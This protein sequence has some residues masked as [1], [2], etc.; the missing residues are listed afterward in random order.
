MAPSSCKSQM[1]ATFLEPLADGEAPV[2]AGTSR[3]QRGLSLSP[4]FR[5][6]ETN[7][8]LSPGS[9]AGRRVPSTGRQWSHPVPGPRMGCREPPGE[10]QGV[11]TQTGAAGCWLARLRAAPAGQKPGH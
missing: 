3:G 10:T 4:P 6:R 9:R 5:L 1:P 7:P 8:P 2:V 11:Q